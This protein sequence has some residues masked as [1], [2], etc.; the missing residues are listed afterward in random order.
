SRVI[1]NIDHVGLIEA[2]HSNGTITTL[3]GNT[4][5]A[6][7]RRVRNGSVVVGYGRPVYADAAP[8]PAG[9]GMLRQGSTGEPVR[10]LQRNLNAVRGP[11]TGARRAGERVA[12]PADQAGAAGPARRDRRRRG[13][14]ADGPGAAAA[15]RCRRRRR[16]GT[17]DDPSPADGP[18]RG[19]VLADET[20]RVAG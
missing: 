5:D 11:A 18:E 17:A 19:L 14:P 9:D 2:V 20:E 1:E 13:R 3:E 10:S 8:L 4:S 12:G 15:R 16:V 7:L 6:F